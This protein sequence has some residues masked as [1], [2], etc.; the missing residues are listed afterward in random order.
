MNIY[1]DVDGVLIRSDGKVA[2]FADDFLILILSN[3]PE[4]TYW[5]TSYC[6]RGQNNVEDVLGPLLKP[7]T[8][9]LIKM[10]RPAIWDT[11]KS[12]GINFRE[13][14]LWFDDNV[15]MEERK[16]LESFDSLACWRKIDLKE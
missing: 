2:A 11:Q 5:L 10:V 9:H 12:E 4:S 6:W 7:R 14:F 1:L 8:K 13:Q 16:L 15:Y 3:W